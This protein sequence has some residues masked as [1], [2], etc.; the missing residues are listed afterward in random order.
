MSLQMTE[1]IEIYLDRFLPRGTTII[2][3]E[4]PLNEGSCVTFRVGNEEQR[5][6][7]DEIMDK[8]K[9][10]TRA[11]ASD[12]N[13]SSCRIPS[14]F[15]LRRLPTQESSAAKRRRGYEIICKRLESAQRMGIQ[16]EEF[17]KGYFEKMYC[18]DFLYL[19][20]E[21]RSK[22]YNVSAIPDKFGRTER[23]IVGWNIDGQEN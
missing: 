15:D 5:V 13:N 3:R 11:F 16:H 21:L 8:V 9:A 12:I 20:E 19:T 22:G 17:Y 10:D 4:N 6:T 1:A 23:I 7:Y 2:S 14:A 18:I